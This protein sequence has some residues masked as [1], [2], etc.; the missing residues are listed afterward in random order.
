MGYLASEVRGSLTLGHETGLPTFANTFFEFIE[1][2]EWEADREKILLLDQLE[3]G[4]QYY[5]IVTTVNGLYRYFMNDIIEVT[6]HFNQCPTIR[7][8][9]KGKGAT[10]ITGEKLY[11][12]QVLDAIQVLEEET[13]IA[14]RFQQWVAEE[15]SSQYLVYL[16]SDDAQFSRIDS[17]ADVLERALCR[18]NME[19]EHKRASGRLKPVQVRLLSKGTGEHYKSFNLAG[20]QREGQYKTLALIYR[21]DCEFPFD[22]YIQKGGKN[23]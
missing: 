17:Y 6:G 5:V 14:V 1:R 18:L 13:N 2:D 4:N 19:Y 15:E 12:I 9:Q 11:E 7:F 22:E 23:G 3:V 20:G 10:N 8:L 16:E 21:K